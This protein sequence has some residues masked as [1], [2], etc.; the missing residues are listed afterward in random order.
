MN[1]KKQLIEEGCSQEYVDGLWEELGYNEI[2]SQ[3]V[4][5]PS[6]LY[7]IAKNRAIEDGQLIDRKTKAPLSVL[8]SFECYKKLGYKKADCLSEMIEKYG[9]SVIE[10]RKKDTRMSLC[11]HI[12]LIFLMKL[13]LLAIEKTNGNVSAMVEAIIK[14]S[15]I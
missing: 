10:E 8:I 9:S 2:P 15:N 3:R 12:P 6:S 11:V 4:I 14:E 7:E 13:K 1:K 5:V